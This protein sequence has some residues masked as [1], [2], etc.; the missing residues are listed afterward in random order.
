MRA[1]LALVL[2]LMSASAAA[3]G[4]WPREAGSVFASISQSY[5]TG[6]A[7]LLAPGRD[8]R[9]ATSLFAEYGLTP[10]VTVGLDAGH[11]RTLESS[12]SS[13][14]AFIRRPIRKGSGGSII[15]GEIGIGFLED[16]SGTQARLRPGISWGRGIET[17]WGAGWL[18]LDT[19]LELRL[20]ANEV[21]LKA[22]A[23]AG[24]KPTDR[25]MLILQLQT[26]RYPGAEPIAR[27]APSLVRRV[28]A[29]S[30]VQLGI[31]ANLAG[32]DAVGVKLATW[33][34]F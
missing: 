27:L 17:R 21:A 18:G 15:S 11:A 33:I 12:F 25:L 5:S 9:R 26:G 1:A 29:R 31:N 14:L 19:S 34:T 6:R 13:A 28:G 2:F 20:P 23:T 24:L 22:D 16:G 10:E 32:D 3:A 4:A 30:H 7:T 8:L